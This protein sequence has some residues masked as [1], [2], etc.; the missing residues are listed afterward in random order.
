MT[1]ISRNTF[2]CFALWCCVATSVAHADEAEDQYRLAAGHYLR[3]NWRLAADEFR[4]FV[5]RYG[6]QQP[7][8]AA[9]AT[10]FLA[11]SM[12]QSGEYDDARVQLK[13]FLRAAADHAYAPRARFRLGEAAYLA[14]DYNLARADLEAF[15]EKHSNSE[16]DEY[17]LPYLAD[18][19]LKAGEAAAAQAAYVEVIER[20][21]ASTLIDESRFGLARALEQQNDFAA[22]ETFYTFLAEKPRHRLASEAQIRLGVLKYKQRQYDEAVG[23]FE[24]LTDHDMPRAEPLYWLGLARYAKRQWSEAAAA[25]TTPSESS[26]FQHADQATFFRG[27]SL[28]QLGKLD[29]AGRQ[30][31]RVLAN[32]PDS[33][34]ADDA[35]LGRVRVAA[36]ENDAAVFA[37]AV[38]QFER[39]FP[40]S[41][42]LDQVH[43]LWGRSLL[44]QGDY[45][46]AIDQLQP[47]VERAT[48]GANAIDESDRYHLALALLGANRYDAA[49]LH[50]D[51]IKLDDADA[52]MGS[53]VHLAR[54][55]ALIALEKHAAAIEPLETFLKDAPNTPETPPAYAQLV[56]AL[57]VTRKYDQARLAQR[58]F[59]VRFGTA[60]SFAP[61]TQFFAEAA[62]A[63]GRK[64]LARELFSELTSDTYPADVRARGLAG[65]LRCDSLAG[66]GESPVGSVGDDEKTYGRLLAEHAD[67]EVVPGA[68]LARAQSLESRDKPI[69]ALAAY[70]TLI[71]KYPASAEAPYALL[72]AASLHAKLEQLSEAD[73]LF[74]RLVNEHRDFEEFDTALYRWAWVLIDLDRDADARAV[75]DRVHRDH[76]SSEY[77][78]D[79]TYRLARDAYQAGSLDRA[80]RLVRQLLEK[81]DATGDVVPHALC[82]LGQIA[83]GKS[84]WRQ[85]AD[86]MRKLLDEYPEH[87]LKT[88]AAYWLAEAA[89]RQQDYATA[90]ARLKQLSTA[91]ADQNDAWLAM[92]PLR[93]AQIL[94]QLE[95]WPDAMELAERIAVDYP[96]FD[97]L[98]EVDYLL[99]RCYANA[100]RFRDA[101]E[102]YRRVVRSKEG[103]KTETAAMA[104][105]MIGET[106]FHQK[107]YDSAIREYAKVEIL[108]AFP[109]WQA[110]ALLQMGRCYEVQGDSRQAEKQYARLLR[111][112]P[113]SHF[114]DQAK[115]RLSTVRGNSADNPTSGEYR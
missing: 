33:D 99:G 19:L 3:Q 97:Q 90:Q 67:S 25:L 76:A 72:A 58:Q 86:A 7:D 102:A 52:S 108:Y 62:L 23:L 21:P 44:R 109:R 94:G 80:E 63:D 83:A 24:K 18:L 60:P 12:L 11:E 35:G 100:A 31:D 43:R 110:A 101:R 47:L 10:F 9:L 22:A 13:N 87:P 20:F 17:A 113:D 112:F 74:Q 27:E 51:G 84:Q 57:A 82:L 78:A 38:K 85:T 28:K 69:A 111:D 81:T 114:T 55:T 79:A 39:Q 93:R 68:V 96:N 41:E 14:G 92:I 88:S 46:A 98:Y 53:A 61:A 29:A 36:A 95:R 105:W 42:H 71:D 1:S 66:A 75:F 30:Y 16:L 15:R 26:D 5:R 2:A 50:L 89:F 34:W 32:W 4:T 6:D 107:D 59:S 64:K 54:A 56:T 65:L 91:T 48:V 37:T 104:Q 106:F 70:R 45:L 103:G 49:L 40:E 115:Q 77:W 73:A 8:R